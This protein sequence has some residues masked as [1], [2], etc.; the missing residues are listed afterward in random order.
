VSAPLQSPPADSLR[1]VLRR[2]YDSPEYEWEEQWDPFG[3]L[4]ELHAALLEWLQG[5]QESH[6]VAYLI[7]FGVDTAL[8][9]GILAHFGYLVWRSLKPRAL[10]EPGV[11][12][13]AEGRRDAAWH[14]EE[15]RRLVRE[16][17]YTEALAYRFTALLLELEARKALVFR[18]SK[19]PAEYVGEA[20][21]DEVGR[22]TLTG[23][24]ATLYRHLFG[25]AP[26]SLDQVQTFDERA[27]E[28]ATRGATG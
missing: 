23:L 22:S 19:T 7:F 13:A 11:A 2:I 20:R 12:R 8:L 9:L 24:V 17:H 18:P 4:R 15:A 5:F 28:L 14:L 3:F 26:C 16:G 10:S 21:L 6:P 1:A 27:S 25:G